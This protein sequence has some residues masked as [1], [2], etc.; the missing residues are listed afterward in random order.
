MLIL[1]IALGGALGAVARYL[2]I[3]SLSSLFNV[4]F[5]IGTLAVNIFGSLA[6]G[7]LVE[8]MMHKISVPME[9][10]ALIIVGFLGSF[11]TFSTFAMDVAGLAGHGFY[12]QAGLYI[13]ASVIL[14]SGAL[15]IGLHIARTL[16]VS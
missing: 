13:M 16:F 3:S 15:L 4:V 9:I 12:H 11:T 8:L 5:P 7:F 1:A 10:R 14:S 6:M 2:V